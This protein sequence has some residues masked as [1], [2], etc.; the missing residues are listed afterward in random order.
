LVT[1]ILVGKSN[2]AIAAAFGLSVQTV[3]NQL[4]TLY[5]KLSVSSRL[6]LAARLRSP[7]DQATEPPSVAD[8]FG[9]RH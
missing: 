8:K 9:D 3:R 7:E 4:T 1:E 6:E 5:R 2:K